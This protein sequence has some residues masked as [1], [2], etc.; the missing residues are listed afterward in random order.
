VWRRG[1]RAASSEAETR[2][3]GRQALE[4]GGGSVAR[5]LVLER[6]GDSPE[7]YPDRPFGGPP[8]LLGPWAL[9]FFG[10]RPRGAF[11]VVCRFVCLL[12]IIFRKG[13]F[14]GY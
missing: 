9:I 1:S 14:P 12:L 2:P 4:R 6:G 3:S 5:R 10:P 13:C 7:G 11:F 8:R